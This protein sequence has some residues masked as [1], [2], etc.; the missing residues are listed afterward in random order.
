[1]A[2]GAPSKPALIELGRLLFFDPRLSANRMQSCASCHQPELAYTDARRV[3]IGSTGEHHTRNVPTLTNIGGRGIDLERQAMRPMLRTHPIELGA[4]GHEREIMSRFANDP[5]YRDLVA[6]AFP[7]TQRRFTLRNAARAIA[8]FE[9]TLTST[10]APF[11]R[12]AAGDHDAMPAGAWRGLQLFSAR[13]CASCHAGTNF[14]RGDDVPTLRNIVSTAPYM[15][16]GS[17]NTIEEVFDRHAPQLSCDE[18]ASMTALLES[19]SSPVM[20]ANGGAQKLV[21][22]PPR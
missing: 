6:R 1:M 14:S 16:D 19:L 5:A 4:L 3:A 8:A 15:R 20:S 21:T 17:A 10:D 9:R 13:G 22:A 18:R 11:D 12:A 7:N 2:S